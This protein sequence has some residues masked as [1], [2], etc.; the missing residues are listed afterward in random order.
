VDLH[1]SYGPLNRAIFERADRVLVPVTP[2]LAAVR[3]AAQLCDLADDLG[4]RDRLALV[5][6]RSNSGISVADLER[7]LKMPALAEIRSSGLLM[8]EAGNEGRTAVEAAPRHRITGDFERLADRVLGTPVR[9]PASQPGFR[10]FSRTA[11]FV[12]G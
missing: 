11:A 3:A 1:G 2:D 4:L 7:T 5:V 6:N 10:L 8:V 12:R 9:V